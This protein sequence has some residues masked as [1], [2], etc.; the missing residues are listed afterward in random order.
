MSQ[1]EPTTEGMK[2]L[3]AKERKFCFKYFELNLNGT[4]AAI[5]AGYAEKSARVT[6][7]R[8]LTKANIRAE[9]ERYLSE[10]AMGANEVLCRLADHA[11]GTMADFIEVD[12]H[13]DHLNLAKAEASGQLHL[14]K[15]FTR[16][17]GENTETITIELYDA[18]AA[19][20]Q[21]GR[22][23]KLFT[24]NVDHT[25]GGDKLTAPQVFLPPIEPD[26]A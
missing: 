12:E 24:D 19:L 10:Q 5:A 26:D 20:V 14:I 13:G 9:I 4:R 8:L 2:P 15:K 21:I 18:Q 11:R 17:V 22:Y 6:A 25:T 1:T 16:H 23:H 3:T 7:S